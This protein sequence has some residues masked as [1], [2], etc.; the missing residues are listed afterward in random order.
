LRILFL[1]R[2]L[3]SL[4]HGHKTRLLTIKERDIGS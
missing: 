4:Q 1:E 3:S 2:G